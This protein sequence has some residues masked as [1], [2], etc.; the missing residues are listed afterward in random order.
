MASNT[1]K[2][3]EGLPH[4]LEELLKETE[5]NNSFV[6][7]AVTNQLTS[8]MESSFAYLYKMQKDSVRFKQYHFQT[9]E[10]LLNTTYSDIQNN[11]KIFGDQLMELEKQE[12]PDPEEIAKIKRKIADLGEVRFG[13]LYLDEKRQVSIM[14]DYDILDSDT[15]E[16]FRVSSYYKEE[17]PLTTLIKEKNI[18]RMIPIAIIDSEVKMNIKIKPLEQG[19]K[20]IFPDMSAKD[21]YT[22]IESQQFHDVCIFFIPNAY[23][24]FANA[25]SKDVLTGKLP[26]ISGMDKLEK[27]GLWFSAIDCGDSQSHLIPTTIEDGYM[28]LELDNA[29]KELVSDV[30][31]I[32]IAAIF[33]QNMRVHNYCSSDGTVP[34]SLKTYTTEEE[35]DKIPE[36]EFFVPS[37][38]GNV[39]PMP[40]PEDKF[41]IFKAVYD[42]TTVGYYEPSYETTVTLY[43]PNIYRISDINLAA[44]SRYR[45]YYFY[46]EMSDIRYT[47][48]FDFY[49]EYMK[50]HYDNKLSIEEIINT[51]YFNKEGY[52]LNYSV[53]DKETDPKTLAKKKLTGDMLTDFYSLFE[54]MMEYCDYKYEYGTPDF[55]TQYVG[56][57]IPLQYKIA[58][59]NEFIKADWTTLPKYVRNEKKTGKLYHF[60]TN[61]INL[62]GRFRRSTRFEDHE[63]TPFM[64]ADGCV[65]CDASDPNAFLVVDSASY[66]ITYE[67]NINDVKWILP[68]AE[69]G[70]YVSF[71]NLDDKYV[72]AFKNDSGTKSL[73]LKIFIDGIICS[74]VSVVHSLGVDYIYLPV[75]MIGENTYIMMEREYT[76]ATPQVV[77]LSFTDAYEWKTIHLIE[78]EN[79]QYTMNDI[80]VYMNNEILDKDSYT[81]K[82][83]RTQVDYFM[84][85]KRHEVVNKYGIVTD[86]NI[87]LSGIKEFPAT[88][89]VVINKR[90]FISYGVANRNGYP[91]FDLTSLAIAPDVKQGRMYFKGRLAPK[92]TFRLVTSAGRNYIQSRVFCEKGDS[93]FFEFS[94]YAKEVVCEVDEFD[95][96]EIFDFSK[97]IDKPIDPEYY[98]VFVNG[99]RLGLP[100]LFA[101]GPYHGVFRGLNSK[102][103]LVIYERE[104]DFEYFGFSKVEA[105]FDEDSLFFYVPNDL[106]HHS[107]MTEAE[108]KKIVNRYIET[109]KNPNAIIKEN[110]ISEEPITFDI[111]DGLLEEMKIFFFEELLPL[112]LANSDTVQFNKLYLSEVFPNLAKEFLVEGEEDDPDTIYLNPDVTARIYDSQTN[113][114]EIIPTSEADPEKEFVMLMGESGVKN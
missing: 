71:T 82:L 99:R 12:D 9:R 33:I 53:S 15:R 88:I 34:V 79:L 107:F 61:T 27:P 1:W 42:G 6:D 90:S 63:S 65:K 37:Y 89:R 32:S 28:N 13:D 14:V 47:P 85:D 91:R 112:G 98:E 64:F 100:N 30:T 76:M 23:V 48:L 2:P 101:F 84:E 110:E 72:F 51:V 108:A 29:T 86:V 44:D 95:P 18:F 19:T 73:D 22:K 39:L 67:V 94:P 17:T 59:M 114:Y 92:E 57:E 36:S 45:V 93:Y 102:N 43:Y 16:R 96:D 24:G 8:T 52:D 70:D 105:G 41:F 3:Y 80:T 5:I 103:S 38:D 26:I 56:D 97:Y 25:T 113:D 21:V 111:E 78:Y 20:I 31:S 69:V 7:S 109:V 106:L 68:S 66:D 4:T 81:G 83:A 40:V 46:E 54:K 75:S 35:Q 58:R 55:M 11:L 87:Q 74:N 60:F 104:R 50:Y 77:E 62:K 49:W 10:F